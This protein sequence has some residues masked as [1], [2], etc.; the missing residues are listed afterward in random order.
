M[1]N[2]QKFLILI[3]LPFFLLSSVMMY[4]NIG[5]PAPAKWHLKE[6]ERL[7]TFN[8]FIQSI[9]LYLVGWFFIIIMAGF[10]TKK[11]IQ[12]DEHINKLWFEEY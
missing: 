1:N 4:N 12:T 11:S 7:I 10:K 9:I 3:L 5:D 8:D 6:S 2:V